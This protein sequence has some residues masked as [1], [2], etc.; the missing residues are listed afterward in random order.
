VV[1]AWEA[2]DWQALKYESWDA[3]CRAEFGMGQIQLAPAQREAVMTVLSGAGMSVRQ[4]ASATGTGK[5]TVSRTL[6]PPGVPDGTQLIPATLEE[7]AA[8]LDELGRQF[9]SHAWRVV[10]VIWENASPIPG[11]GK[12]DLSQFAAALS[13]GETIKALFGEFPVLWQMW[14]KF[15]LAEPLPPFVETYEI[16]SMP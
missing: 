7:C 11:D 15:R 10:Q 3:Y 2:R 1:A 6:N 13:N 12:M 5:S 14:D 8:A 16:I 9:D 4:I